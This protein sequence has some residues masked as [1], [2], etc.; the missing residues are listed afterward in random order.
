MTFLAANCGWLF[1]AAFV[2]VATSMVLMLRNM[3]NPN[4]RLN[5]MIEGGS[6]FKGMI[7]VILSGLAGIALGIL[8]IVGFIIMLSMKYPLQ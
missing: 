3:S 8:S 1:L 4:E 6:P 5:A 7:P 2:L